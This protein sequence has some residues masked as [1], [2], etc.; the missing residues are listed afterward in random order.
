MKL[1]MNVKNLEGKKVI[2]M[3]IEKYDVDNISYSHLPKFKKS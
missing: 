1:G 3:I 2:H